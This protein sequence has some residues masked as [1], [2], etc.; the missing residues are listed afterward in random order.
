MTT[1][2]AAAPFLPFVGIVAA[3]AAVA[4]VFA[5]PSPRARAVAAIA[6]LA[7][8][9]VLLVGE[10]WDSPAIG[11]LRDRPAVLVVAALLSMR[12]RRAI[13]HGQLHPSA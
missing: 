3:A 7:L 6:A 10:L 5:L 9:P 8:A 4:A 2:L 13:T 12:G 11:N 1:P